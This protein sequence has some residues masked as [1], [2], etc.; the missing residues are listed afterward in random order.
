M[1]VRAKAFRQADV[2]RAVKGAKAAGIDVARVEIG[3]DGRIVV[4][5]G[6]PE[7]IEPENLSPL[8]RWRRSQGARR[9]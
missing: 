1:S 4:V 6:L 8:E 7:P 5:A 9:A 2:S 3:L